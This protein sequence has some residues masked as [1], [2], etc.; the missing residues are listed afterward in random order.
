MRKVSHVTAHATVVAT[1]LTAIQTLVSGVGADML[2]YA[3]QDCVGQALS[4]VGSMVFVGCSWVEAIVRVRRAPLGLFVVFESLQEAHGSAW[5][6][7]QWLETG[8]AIDS[9]HGVWR[10]NNA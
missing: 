10:G 8:R 4:V 5:R 6:T 7:E 3:S 1:I 9:R 2:E